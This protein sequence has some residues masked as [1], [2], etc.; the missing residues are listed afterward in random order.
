MP[1]SM[2]LVSNLSCSQNPMG[3]KRTWQQVKVKYKNIIQSAKK[4]VKQQ[5]TEE[6]RPESPEVKSV[7]P[8]ALQQD[9]GRPMK[10]GIA[11]G[12]SCVEPASCLRH[13]YAKMTGHSVT[14]LQPPIIVVDPE[15]ES[16]EGTEPHPEYAEPGPA[17]NRERNAESQEDMRSLYKRYLEQEISYRQLKMRK[18]EK[19]MQLLDKQL[20]DDHPGTSK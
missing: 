1:K 17:G 14:L 19:E 11:G 3:I 20:L 15:E 9:G 10:W 13:S 5:K 6:E 18:L 12:S 16:S 7:E 2:T 4:R 8:L